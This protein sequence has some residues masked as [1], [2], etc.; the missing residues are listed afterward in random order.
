MIVSIKFGLIYIVCAYIS[1]YMYDVY[2]YYYFEL[3][4]YCPLLSFFKLTDAEASTKEIRKF[5]P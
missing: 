5:V 4:Q 1:V 2:Y 3:K